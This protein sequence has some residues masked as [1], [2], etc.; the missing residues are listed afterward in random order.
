MAALTILN[1]QRNHGRQSNVD[2][3]LVQRPLGRIFSEAQPSRSI[4]R[5]RGVFA[6]VG[7]CTTPTPERFRGSTSFLLNLVAACRH[8]DEFLR[9]MS[10]SRPIGVFDSGIGGLTVAKALQ[11]LLPN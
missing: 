1:S 5:K 9:G 3:I 7:R 8:R 10:D 11:E 2:T 6:R 4:I